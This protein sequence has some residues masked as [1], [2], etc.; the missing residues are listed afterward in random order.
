MEG[1]ITGG[2]LSGPL[3]EK[4]DSTF[5]E[6]DLSG[7]WEIQE[8]ERTYLATLDRNGNG[9]Y[10]WQNGRIMTTG[11]S[12]R[13][14]KGTWHQTGNDREGG[15]E[16][17]LSEDGVEAEGV[18]WYTRVGI[19]YNIPPKEWGGSFIWSRTHF[20]SAT[21]EGCCEETVSHPSTRLIQGNH[22]QEDQ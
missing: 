18:W 11:F 13:L 20:K 6:V 17:L 5:E 10:T 21:S 22:G 12:D 15:F 8:E 2:S 14:W 3:D 1:A 7:Q 9:S 19:Q 4:G 16:I